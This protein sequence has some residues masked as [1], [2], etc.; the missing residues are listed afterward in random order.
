MP[1]ARPLPSNRMAHYTPGAVQ[2]RAAE[3]GQ[4][5]TISGYG[6]VFY[7]AADPGTEY[8]IWD[9]LVERIM[10]GAFDRAIREDDVRSFFNHNPDMIL[11]RSTAG[12]LKLSVDAKGLR[13]EVQ[14]PASRADVIE[15]LYRGDV[16]GSSFMFI[17]DDVQ[18]RIT[19][20][21]EI[22]E[23]LAVRL[24]EVGPVVFP[25]YQSATSE[26]RAR[27]IEDLRR[28]LRVDASAARSRRARVVSVAEQ[29][30][31]GR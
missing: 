21:V 25:A 16:S 17:A 5:A 2:C 3:E 24:L 27:H 30:R 14:P 4:P 26:V 19:D 20:G 6:A 29:L 23:I 8:R 9:D 18:F 12:T 15:S 7:D 28:V 22:V 13:Y 11:G 31:A 1:T 10:P